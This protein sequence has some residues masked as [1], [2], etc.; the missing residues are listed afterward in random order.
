MSRVR[1][2]NRG[3]GVRADHRPGPV[4][5]NL[6]RVPVRRP[7]GRPGL[8]REAGR[9]RKAP[10]R[11][12]ARRRD[13][14]HACR[15]RRGAYRFASRPVAT[16]FLGRRLERCPRPHHRPHRRIRRGA[17]QPPYSRAGRPFRAPDGHRLSLRMEPVPGRPPPRVFG[18]GRRRVLTW[19]HPVDRAAF[20]AGAHPVPRFPGPSAV[21]EPPRMAARRPGVSRD[22]R[23]GRGPR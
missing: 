10:R 8:P 17:H 12:A 1:S 4:P 23:G 16:E 19:Q 22:P 15:S 13:Q 6:A 18:T 3:V 14:R 20:E 7:G 21:L 2:G 5:R 11:V 9:C